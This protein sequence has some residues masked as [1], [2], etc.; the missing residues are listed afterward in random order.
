MNNIIYETIC[1]D[2]KVLTKIDFIIYVT[3]LIKKKQNNY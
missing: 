2:K 3:T 1:Y